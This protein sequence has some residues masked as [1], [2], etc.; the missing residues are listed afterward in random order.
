MT[1]TRLRW[2]RRLQ[3]GIWILVFAGVGCSGGDGS[4]DWHG[5]HAS[6]DLHGDGT[7]WLS[8]SDLDVLGSES[9]GYPISL[10]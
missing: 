10:G 8:G 4:I 5:T 3:A 9:V 7:G 6:I 2:L 1:F